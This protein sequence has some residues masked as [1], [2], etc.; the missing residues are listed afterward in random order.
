DLD[1]SEAEILAQMKA[2]TRYNIRLAKRRGVKIRQ[3]INQEDIDA[4][5]KLI[6]ITSQ[7]D[8]FKAH[9]AAY[10]Q[11]MADFFGC[12]GLLKIFL[13][14]YKDQVLAANLVFFWG[15]R[16][17]YLHGASGN[18]HRNLMAPHLLQWTQILEAKKQGRGEYDFWGIAGEAK[19]VKCKAKSWEGITRFKKGFGGRE[20]SYAGTYDIILNN[21]WYKIYRLLRK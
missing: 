12:Q 13:A 15:K 9:S 5:L 21:F 1:Q 6:A 10:Y 2:K 7:R 19:S 18:S 4:F 20:I 14:E 17:T 16:A 11:K 8:H 3:S